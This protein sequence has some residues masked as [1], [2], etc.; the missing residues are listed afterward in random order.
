MDMH[1]LVIGLIIGFS[2]AAPVGPIGVL[3]IRR[4]LAEG[5]LHGLVSGLGAAT[6]DAIYGGI[7]G[8]GLTFISDMLVQQQIWLRFFGGVFLCFL[9]LKTLLAKP[10]EKS[11]SEKR[12]GLLGS[13]GSTFFLTLTNPMTILSFA[14][15]F[16]GIG[17]GS[18][19]VDYGSA[20]LLVFSVFAGSALWWLILSGSVSLLRKK[21]TPRVLRWINMVSG[22]IIMGFGVFALVSIVL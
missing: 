20:A 16:A 1:F 17:L 15:V 21:V 6:A 12:T 7:A 9:G 18:T 13:Y 4:T 11:P 14:A 10:S 22:A 2:I 8:F 5:R 3:C 19:L